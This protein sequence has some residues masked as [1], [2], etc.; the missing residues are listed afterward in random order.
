LAAATGSHAGMKLSGIRLHLLLLG[1]G[2]AFFLVSVLAF[3]FIENRIADLQQSLN[4]R[5]NI[6]A[7]QA[8]TASVYGI[9]SKNKLILQELANTI[10]LEKDVVAVRIVD[11]AGRELASTKWVPQPDKSLLLSFQSPVVFSPIQNKAKS[12]D[13]DELAYFFLSDSGTD[14]RKIGRVEVKLSLASTLETQRTFL[15][16]S[17]VITASGLLITVM[18]ALRLG[19]LISKPIT[20]LTRAVKEISEGNMDARA[21][22]IADS[23]LEELRQG[24]N[25]MAIGLQKTQ[26]Y[27]EQQVD[28]ATNQLRFTLKSLEQKNRS[29]ENA[30]RLA[31]AQNKIKSQFLAHISHEI[32]TPMSGIIGFADLLSKTNLTRKQAEQIRLMKNSA[33]NLMTIVNEI[34]DH[35]SLESGKFKINFK[36]FNFH[37]CLEATVSLLSTQADNVPVILDIDPDIPAI[38]YNDP[39]RLQQI[40]GNL[41][42]NAIKFTR[43]GHIIIR[44]RQIKPHS[45]LVSIS[46]TG[47]GIPEK[48]RQELFTPFL[49]IDDYALSHEIGT[50]L[51]L[52]ISKNIIERLRGSI[53][54]LTRENV[55]STFWFDFPII[56][57]E[58]QEEPLCRCTAIVIDHF[59]LRRTAFH[60]QLNRLGCR[61]YSFSTAAEF[62]KHKPYSLDV[63]FY[64]PATA[65]HHSSHLQKTLNLIRL[66]SLAPIVLVQDQSNQPLEIF[67]HSV[68]SLPCRSVFLASTLESVLGRQQSPLSQT[69]S[70]APDRQFAILIADDN[71]INR[72]LFK[73]QLENS[74]T[75]ITLASNGSEAL[76][77][78]HKI[79]FDLVLLDLQMPDISGMEIIRQIKANHSLNHATPFIA[80]TAHAH[81]NQRSMVINAGFDECLIKPV[82]AEQLNEILDLWQIHTTE[83]ALPPIEKR[84]ETV[85]DTDV[86]P[87]VIMLKKTRQNRELATTLFNK[88]FAELPRQI[89]A[90]E[91]ALEQQ[92]M[93]HAREVTHKLLGSASFCG[94]TDIQETALQLETCLLADNPDDA[95][96]CFSDLQKCVQLF[97]RQQERIMEQLTITQ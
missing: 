94:L 10:L 74:F 45:L 75:N 32:R 57:V 7:R 60:K 65:S 48:H 62:I 50:G 35:S 56:E 22:F 61:T 63:I 52:T 59:K 40:L 6:I 27:L 36:T 78:L 33:T 19:M 71:D 46:D 88:L 26:Q 47:P 38:I 96:S 28:N 64:T 12:I 41:L 81:Q 73:S 90:I 42:G 24:F 67:N 70:K 72:L 14:S 9:S 95:E 4:D 11:K 21:D 8:A 80:V 49:Q 68:V 16:N 3:Y 97:I 77:L 84:E 43:H 91:Q 18:L 89:L 51:G 23:E 25:S 53:G 30:R 93:A 69:I 82:S 29:L 79:E 86:D 1:I 76:Q 92:D 15:F 17:L 87:V 44:C 83:S 20:K 34:L 31:V 85:V 54:V 5:G 66:I 55:G 13:S 58:Q 37:E 39:I 2:P